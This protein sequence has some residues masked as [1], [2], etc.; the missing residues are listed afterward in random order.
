MPGAY[1]TI[2]TSAQTDAYPIEISVE[3]MSAWMAQPEH[4]SSDRLTVLDVREDVEIRT[5]A[6]S[7]FVHIPLME[8][9]ARTAGSIPRL[10]FTSA[11]KQGAHQTKRQIGRS[12]A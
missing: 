2:Q 1:M 3:E 11:S 7:E 4:R 12:R 5:A 8:V 10:P 9:P 6:L